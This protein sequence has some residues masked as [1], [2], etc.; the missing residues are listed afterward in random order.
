[1][2]NLVRLVIEIMTY[3]IM[4][5]CTLLVNQDKYLKIEVMVYAMYPFHHMSVF[6]RFIYHMLD[7]YKLHLTSTIFSL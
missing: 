5:S 2:Q 7:I 6:S 1:M 3:G 4:M